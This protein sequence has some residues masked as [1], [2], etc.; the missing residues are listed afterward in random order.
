VLDVDGEFTTHPELVH[1]VRAGEPIRALQR[2]LE[3]LMQLRSRA[4]TQRPGRRRCTQVG[5]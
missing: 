5:A 4:A 1:G 2:L 3:A